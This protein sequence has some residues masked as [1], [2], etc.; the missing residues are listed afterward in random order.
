MAQGPEIKQKFG[1]KKLFRK[2]KLGWVEKSDEK[3]QIYPKSAWIGK[4]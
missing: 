3:D 4:N 2:D 1:L